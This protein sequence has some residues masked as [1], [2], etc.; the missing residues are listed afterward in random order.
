MAMIPP[1]NKCLSKWRGTSLDALSSIRLSS[2]STQHNTITI[3]NTN[4]YHTCFTP[5]TYLHNERW[6]SEIHLL[7]DLWATSYP[8]EH[9]AFKAIQYTQFLPPASSKCQI[10]LRWP[11]PRCSSATASLIYPLLQIILLSLTRRIRIYNLDIALLAPFTLWTFIDSIV[12][13]ELR[14]RTTMLRS[15]LDTKF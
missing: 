15:L 9:I 11:L 13:T 5:L 3:Q 8:T 6:R 7:P 12:G 14:R 2:K 1:E 10:T 4:I